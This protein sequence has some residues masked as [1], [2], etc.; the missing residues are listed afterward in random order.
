M[1]IYKDFTVFTIGFESGFEIKLIFLLK[2]RTI[3]KMFQSNFEIL[4][5]KSDFRRFEYMKFIK[6]VKC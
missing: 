2:A 3:V 4:I 5:H 1:T 6:I